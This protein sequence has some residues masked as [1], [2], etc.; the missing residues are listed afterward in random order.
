MA[1]RDHRDFSGGSP[2]V[3]EPA[4]STAGNERCLGVGVASTVVAVLGGQRPLRLGVPIPVSGMRS[5]PVTEQDGS[6]PPAVI[7]TFHEV[8]VMG[9]DAG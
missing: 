3:V 7:A 6:I 1:T 9:P 8:E 2:A 5:Q 4:R